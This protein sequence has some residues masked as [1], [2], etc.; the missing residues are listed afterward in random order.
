MLVGSC[1]WPVG[2]VWCRWNRRVTSSI[3]VAAITSRPTTGQSGFGAH[4]SAM[5]APISVSVMTGSIQLVSGTGCDGRCAN[6]AC[7]RRWHSCR[8][9]HS[10]SAKPSVKPLSNADHMNVN[11]PFVVGGRLYNAPD[12]RA[13]GWWRIESNAVPPGT[14]KGGG[15]IVVCGAGRFPRPGSRAPRLCVPM[16]CSGWWYMCGSYRMLFYWM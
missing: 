11:L 10:W 15:A 6:R 5:T 4:S 9:W 3:P 2:V 12:L 8:R 1:G 7:R 14:Q 13:A 16:R